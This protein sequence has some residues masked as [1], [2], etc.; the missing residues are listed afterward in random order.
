MPRGSMRPTLRLSV[1]LSTAALL[2]ALAAGAVPAAA[3]DSAAVNP[4]TVT[5]KLDNAQVRVLESTLKPG[6]KEQLHSHPASVI[7][8][9]EGGKI[10]NHTP[11]GKTT[12]TELAAGAT[13]YREPLTH[14]AENIG[15]TTVHLILVEL[16]DHK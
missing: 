12:E 1:W 9:L 11:D 3:Q 2:G 14:W 5:V 6:Q 10:R 4:N 15:T 8:V 7:Y 13:V 16:K